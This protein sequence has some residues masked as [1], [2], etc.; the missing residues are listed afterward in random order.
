MPQIKRRFIK[1]SSTPE[2][3]NSKCNLCLEEKKNRIRYKFRG[4]LLNK[5]NELIFKCHHKNECV[6]C[7]MAF[8]LSGLFNAKSI[9][10]ER[11]KWYFLTIARSIRSSCLSQEY[12]FESERNRATGVRTHLLSF[13][14]PVL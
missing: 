9:L 13:C 3:F 10:V 11:R 4:Q 14:S 1:K 5:R 2:S 12:L 7:L 6:C 8:Q